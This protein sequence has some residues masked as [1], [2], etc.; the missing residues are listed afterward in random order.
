MVLLGYIFHFVKEIC[1]YVESPKKGIP[2][3]FYLFIFFGQKYVMVAP[4]FFVCLPWVEGPCGGRLVF[5][6]A[7]RDAYD[8]WP[9]TCLEYAFPG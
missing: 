9:L 6:M 5:F 8:L 1:F 3:N 7:V 2:P 4:Q